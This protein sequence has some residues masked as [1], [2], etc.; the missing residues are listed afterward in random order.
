MGSRLQLG[1]YPGMIGRPDPMVLKNSHRHQVGRREIQRK[2]TGPMINMNDPTFHI[3]ISRSLTA[4]RKSTL[5][6]NMQCLT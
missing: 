6:I 5:T 3:L 4:E 2:A 1:T